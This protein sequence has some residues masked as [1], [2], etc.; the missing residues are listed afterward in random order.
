MSAILIITHTQGTE[1]ADLCAVMAYIIATSITRA[2]GSKDILENLPNE[3]RV[4]IKD[5]SFT[6]T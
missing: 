4:G 2:D 6:P 3:V 1:A 5:E